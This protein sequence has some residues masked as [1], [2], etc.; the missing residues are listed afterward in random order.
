MTYGDRGPD[1]ASGVTVALAGGAASG[2]GA[3]GEND[4]L[5][6]V[7]SLQ[8]TARN[9]TLSGDDG[10]QPIQGLGGNDTLTGG[11]GFDLLYGGD[12][13]DA[14]D[15]VDQGFD[16]VSCGGPQS[17]DTASVDDGDDVGRLPRR[18]RRP[19]DLPRCPSRSRPTSLRPGS[20]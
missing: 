9:D 20:G 4:T 15:A 14:I 10:A 6:G 13:N 8:G 19:V 11:K 1:A 12:G 5:A 18:G 16:R 7:E 3:P 2:A 17:G